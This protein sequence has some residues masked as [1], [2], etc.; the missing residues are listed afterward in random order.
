MFNQ[1]KNFFGN[2][3]L[4]NQIKAKK[5]KHAFMPFDKADEIGIIYNAEDMKNE[6]KVQQFASELRSEGKKVFLLGFINKKEMPYK[7][8]PH[9]N[10]ELFL[11]TNLTFFNLPDADKIGRFID[12]KFD[13]LFNIYNEET[14]ALQGISVLSKSKYQLGAQMNHATKLFDLTIDTGN[15]K[16]IYYLAKQM[17]YYLKV[18]LP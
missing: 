12:M 18:I 1:I 4:T 11:N 5:E 9:I 3:I 7:R 6:Q 14:L 10:S 17:E 16:D 8:V 15:N 13:I 2:I